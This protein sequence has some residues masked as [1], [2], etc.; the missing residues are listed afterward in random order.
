MAGARH[1]DER[2]VRE[3]NTHGLALTSVT[4]TD[5]NEAAVDAGGRDP[6]AAVCA[7]AVAEGKWRDH[8]IALRN[9]AHLGADGV[10]HA[11]EFVADRPRREWSLSPVEPQ[12]GTTDT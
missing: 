5:R 10:D 12:I 4:V 1:P 2:P 11:D 7:R 6:V 3:R 8:E 9:V